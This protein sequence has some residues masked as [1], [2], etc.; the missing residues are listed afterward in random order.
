LLD[1]RTLPSSIDQSARRHISS[2]AAYVAEWRASVFLDG[3]DGLQGR[4]SLSAKDF[5]AAA[6]SGASPAV[7][8]RRRLALEE[9]FFFQSGR[10][11]T[12][13]YVVKEP[14]LAGHFRSMPAC[15]PF[16]N[17]DR[18]G[19]AAAVL[20]E[21]AAVW[22]AEFQM[23]VMTQDH[24]FTTPATAAENPAAATLSPPSAVQC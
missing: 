17:P 3:R 22:R 24:V 8:R 15:T 19:S 12:V 18:P 5:R 10:S 1:C 2:S 9:T 4:F 6:G 11:S 7:E 21:T 23:A 16:W 14:P 20:Q 13:L